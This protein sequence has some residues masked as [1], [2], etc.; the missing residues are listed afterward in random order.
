M[1]K[2]WQCWIKDR[3]GMGVMVPVLMYGDTRDPVQSG[4]IVYDVNRD[5]TFI[6]AAWSVKHDEVT[7][8]TP[9]GLYIY[10][11]SDSLELRERE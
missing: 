7:L 1:S 8:L 3:N 5:A 4:D 11:S 2:R 9:D 10:A 6:V